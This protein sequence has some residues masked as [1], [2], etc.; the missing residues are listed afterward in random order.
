MR[1]VFLLFLFTS[2]Q[3]LCAQPTVS[4]GKTPAWVTQYDFSNISDTTETPNGYAYLLISKQSQLE[5]KEDYYK[6]VMKVTSEKGLATVASINEYFD[7]SFQ[8]LT[9]HELNII[10][11]GKTI[12]KLN[13]AKFDVLRRE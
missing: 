9:F 4:Q 7:P 3:V 1:F 13:P 12:N 6:Y 5:S 11:N 2:F 8:K 10:R